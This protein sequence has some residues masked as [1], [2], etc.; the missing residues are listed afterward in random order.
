MTTAVVFD[1]GGVLIDWNPR[2]LYRRV[3]AGDTAAMEDFLANVCTP[4][5]N[6]QQDLGRTWA[7]AVAECSARFPQH[8]ALIRLYAERWDEMVTGAIEPT[9][10]ILKALKAA[11]WPL[12][13]ITNFSAETYPRMVERFSFLQLF[14]GIVVSGYERVGKPDRAIYRILFERYRLEPGHCLFI[15][16]AALN[17]EGSEAVGM[18]AIHYHSPQQLAAD[19]AARGVVH[20]PGGGHFAVL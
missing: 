19:L 9:V 16:D 12:Y 13:A 2:H 4:A 20:A 5:W 15:D 3:F 7:D 17:V 10:D 6:H 11:G 1:L 8:A 18:P 14:D